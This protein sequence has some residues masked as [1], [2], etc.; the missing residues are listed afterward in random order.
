MASC[1]T[2]GVTSNVQ[3]TPLHTHDPLPVS[4]P[5]LSQSSCNSGAANTSTA[6]IISLISMCGSYR[7]VGCLQ[8]RIELLEGKAYYLES[9]KLKLFQN[10]IPETMSLK[11]DRVR[12]LQYIQRARAAKLLRNQLGNNLR[13]ASQM[14]MGVIL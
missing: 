5:V 8:P 3:S 13:D 2:S 10:P 1:I 4:N 11:L 6:A 12:D 7:F 14:L 9:F